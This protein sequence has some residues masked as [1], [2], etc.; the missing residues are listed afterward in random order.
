MQKKLEN[1]NLSPSTLDDAED[2]LMELE[3]LNK[4][5]ISTKKIWNDGK[6]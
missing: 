1:I 4:M 5:L 6:S 3:S 2:S